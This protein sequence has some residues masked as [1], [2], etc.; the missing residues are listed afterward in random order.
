[1]KSRT[2][3]YKTAWLR[4]NLQRFLP[5]WA[6][7]TVCLLLGLTM[8]AGSRDRFYFIM[9]L[10]ACSRIMAVVNCGYALLTAQ[11]LF[12]D[13]YD[14]RMC[15]GIHSLPIRREELFG[16]NILAGLLFSLI[17]TAVMTICAFPLA[18]G[19]QVP[20]A[21]YVPA[22]WFAAANLEYLVFFSLAVLCAFLSGNRFSMA[23]IYGILNFGSLLLYLM[24]E[25]IYMPLL[26]GVALPFAPFDRF[27]PAVRITREPLLLVERMGE[28]DPG[29]YQLQSGSWT[30]L[31]ICA[32]AGILLLLL[33]LQV[34]RK[35][36]LEA[37]GEFIAVKGLRPVF[38]CLFSL[39]GCTGLNLV[40][41]LFFGYRNDSRI[42]IL[43]AAVGLVAGWFIAMMLLQKSARVFTRKSFLGAALLLA[44]VAG[45]VLLTALDILGIASWVPEP[46][47]VKSVVLIP[48]Y[49]N[50]GE[51]WDNRENYRI[52]DQAGLEAVTRVHA[53]AI[54]EDLTREDA[55]YYY[56]YDIPG[57]NEQLRYTVPLSIE[58]HMQDGSVSRRFYFVYADSQ[59]G[60]L[61]KS[62][63]SR[64]PLATGAPRILDTTQ[65]ASWINVR[66]YPIEEAFLTAED[67][68]ALMDAIRRD[69]REGTL[70]QLPE[71]H[72]VPICEGEAETIQSLDLSMGFGS[73]DRQEYLYL[74]VYSDSSHTLSWL[75]QRG[76]IK[77]VVDGLE[78]LTE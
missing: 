31:L 61:L 73:G 57:E 45:S 65:A 53:L 33:S 38:L 68:M 3:S 74:E 66:G 48:G 1:M 35:R 20:G 44:L 12:G 23:V 52:T 40:A 7:Y 32:G 41:S 76:V 75:R 51:Y 5:F 78:S 22:L 27:S 15:F 9:N 36:S 72:P 21:G 55:R 11:L 37:A 50:F 25:S 58:Y 46:Q 60:T 49:H 70:A 62:L 63:Y 69:C 47:Q 56:D 34:Y 77:T 4:K 29:H 59:A 10:A 67:T 13:L 42:G 17:P 26:Q 24:V 8:L 39:F 14:S 18:L 64:A 71:F 28:T 2:S 54:E 16:L 30:Y 19:S 43:F 6:L